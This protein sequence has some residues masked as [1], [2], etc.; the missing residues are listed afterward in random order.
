M[1]DILVQ[2]ALKASFEQKI[3]IITD[4]MALA[5]KS[6][7]KSVDDVEVDMETQDAIW[8]SGERMQNCVFVYVRLDDKEP[9][10]GRDVLN[11]KIPGILA[12]TFNIP[13]DKIF[14][15]FNV[16]KYCEKKK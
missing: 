12:N 5:A 8:F 3:H 6:F 11:E 1:I 14:V 7:S 10:S 16:Y 15:I 4:L 2:A 9:M 13:K